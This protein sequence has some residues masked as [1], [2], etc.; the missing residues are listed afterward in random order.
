MELPLLHREPSLVV[1]DKPAGLPVEADSAHSVVA[2]LARQLAPPGGRAWPRVVHRLDRD[3]SGCLV[4]ALNKSAEQGILRAF[5]EGAVKKQYLALVQGEPPD[6]GH[7]DT[8]Y[9]PD[10]R[11]RRRFTTH[12]DTPRRALLDFQVRDRLH[13]VALVS[14]VLLT[15]RTH[16]IRVQFAEAGFPLLGDPTY[17]VPAPEG[18]PLARVALH[19]EQLSFPH[20]VQPVAVECSAPLPA[21]MAGAM[22]A[23]R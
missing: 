6:Q 13:G 9:G 18:G 11:D 3:T 2:I 21:D 14:V 10:P 12:L 7:F 16:Q 4:V 8:P 15:G 20:P 23:L 17:G 22:V 1:I 19:A 5:D